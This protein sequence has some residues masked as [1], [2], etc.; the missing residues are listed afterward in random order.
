MRLLKSNV[1]NKFKG[2]NILEVSNHSAIDYKD[3]LLHG[4]TFSIGNLVNLK[5]ELEF[6]TNLVLQGWGREGSNP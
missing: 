2:E 6:P 4:D 1:K 5:G 3:I